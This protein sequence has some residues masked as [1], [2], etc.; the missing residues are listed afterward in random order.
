MKIGNLE[1]YGI[2]YK[3]TNLINGKVY[4]GQT[5]NKNGFNGRYD[6]KGKGVERTYKKHENYK[7]LGYGYNKHLFDSIMKHGFDAFKVDEIF[8][9]S[10]SKEELNIKEKCWIQFY[11]SYKDG[12]NNNLGGDGNS[13]YEG[14]KGE[15]NPMAKPIIQLNLDGS[16]VRKWS[17][18]EHASQELN[19]SK[20]TISNMCNEKLDKNGYGYKSAG[21]FLWMLLEDYNDGKEIIYNNMVGEYNKEP[22]IQL[23]LKGKFIR[24]FE[25]ISEASRTIKG[26]T[27]GKISKC[28]QNK[29]KSHGGFMWIYKKNYSTNNEYCWN[30]IHNGEKVSIICLTTLECF[31]AIKDANLKYFNGKCSHICDS[32]NNK[33]NY[34][35]KLED[36]TKLQWKYIENLTPEEYI[37]YDIENRL[38]DLHNR[39]L[40][41]AV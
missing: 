26:I 13:G 22:V 20:S 3:I 31:E 7:K 28:C 40:V 19:I 29:R 5:V 23:S 25:S 11:D 2:I 10:F 6:R 1:V 24:E 30:G 41:Q 21:G 27:T 35:G 9:I 34:C 14:L 38:K 8:D 18:M 4:I 37:T 17:C 16:F 15:N 39:E 32:C 33:R 12:Y 36:G